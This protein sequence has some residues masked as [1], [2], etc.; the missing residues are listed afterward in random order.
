MK[1]ATF[2]L[3]SGLGYLAAGLVGL[4]P[5]TLMPPPLDAPPATFTLLYGYLL[6]LFPTN[7]VH[8]ALHLAV[9][10]WGIAAW[11]GAASATMYARALAVLFGALAALGLLPFFATLL[12]WMPI[13]GND[14]WLHGLTAAIAA[15]FGWRG[16]MPRAE[17]RSGRLDRRQ[18]IDPV[19][20]ERRLGAAERRFAQARMMAGI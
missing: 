9:G 20:A 13:Y 11:R 1:T 15:Y 17:R 8:T 10:V 12:G 4:V 16:E 7:V 3:V 5:A 14:V 18:R 2:A 6:G 19:A